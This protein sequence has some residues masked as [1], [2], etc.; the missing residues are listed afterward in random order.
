[1]QAEGDDARC[2]KD[3]H[4][5]CYVLAPTE[6]PSMAAVA[7]LLLDAMHGEHRW[8]MPRDALARIETLGHG[9]FGEVRGVKAAGRLTKG[10]LAFEQLASPM[11]LWVWTQRGAQN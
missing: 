10:F 7:D 11:H 3:V 4:E 8:E 9:Q 5:A 2:L 1:M 6:R